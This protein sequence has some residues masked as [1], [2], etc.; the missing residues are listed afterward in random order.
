MAVTIRGTPASGS[1][2]AN[3]TTT[4][5]I[6]VPAGAQAGDYAHF[7]LTFNV[8]STITP[9]TG[10]TVTPMV[11][12]INN[13]NYLYV[14]EKTLTG[15]DLGGSLAST[16]SVSGVSA[17][18]CVVYSGAAGLDATSAVG[19]NASFGTAVT[20]PAVTPV[21]GDCLQ[22]YVV[23]AAGGTAST[24]VAESTPTGFTEDVDNSTSGPAGVFWR[25]HAVG[26]AQLAGQ[27]GVAQSALSVTASQTVRYVAYAFTLAPAV[28]D[29]GVW[30]YQK[31]VTIG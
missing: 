16:S 14:Y 31:L 15:G 17:A 6:T 2:S 9:P 19:N 20:V 29:T 3:A 27:A 30:T 22:L 18:S 5:A 23:S 12:S 24:A 10:W 4:P 8:T 7:V 26:H 11:S 21:A 13:N 28:V 25:G 1:T